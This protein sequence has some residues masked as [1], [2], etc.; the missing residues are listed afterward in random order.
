[1]CVRAGPSAT[2]TLVCGVVQGVPAPDIQWLKDGEA[3]PKTLSPRFNSE[4]TSS[5]LTLILPLDASPSSKGE[6]EGN[7]SCVAT[8]EA[9]IT[10]A[11][12]YV[13]LFGGIFSQTHNIL[14]II[15]L[16]FCRYPYTIGYH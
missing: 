7:Y 10:T 11:S 15:T 14:L 5:S 1:M 9:G 12:T 4:N 13:I 16:H 3:L 2:L 6:I 8:N